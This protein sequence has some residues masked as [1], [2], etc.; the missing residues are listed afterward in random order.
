V[1]RWY[2]ICEKEY[3][4]DLIVFFKFTPKMIIN[5]INGRN[6]VFKVVVVITN[7]PENGE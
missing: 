5:T 3:F 1:S 4:A 2:L 7:V 6:I